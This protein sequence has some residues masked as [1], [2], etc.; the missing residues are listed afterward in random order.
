MPDQTAPVAATAAAASQPAAQSFAIAGAIPASQAAPPPLP[1]QA[2][3][4][5]ASQTGQDSPHPAMVPGSGVGTNPAP[6]AAA[7]PPHSPRAAFAA[8]RVREV[9][10]AFSSRLSAVQADLDDVEKNAAAKTIARLNSQLT[11]LAAQEKAA[12]VN[13][14]NQGGGIDELFAAITDPLLQAQIKTL[15]G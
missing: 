9:L 12:V 3:P 10:A 2:A 11:D 4:Q 1:A 14:V 5:Q 8:L 15:V 13:L 6:N 7:K